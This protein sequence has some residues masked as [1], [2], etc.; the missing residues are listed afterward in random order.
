MAHS[1]VFFPDYRAAN[2]YQSLLYEHSAPE[3]HPR[4]ATIGEAL[5][6]RARQGFEDG[7]IFHLHWEDAVYRTEPDEGA[8]RAAAE[9]FVVDL[10]RFLDG[11]GMVL[12]T[13]HNAAP[14]DD[15]FPAVQAA[16]RTALV[17]LVDLVHVHGFEA[18]GWARATLGIGPER[19]VVVPH[20]NYAPRFHPKSGPKAQ[21]RKALGLAEG[22]RVL[23]L[24]GRLD[25]Y[26]GAAEL[27]EATARLDRPD[28]QVILAGRQVVPLD[29]LLAA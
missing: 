24:F 8:A 1:L 14:H 16:L 19:L 15:R 25:A 10:E 2:P 22:G 29:P 9:R 11:G 28:L 17:Q 23:L 13:V 12:W 18:A 6:L 5:E 21:G 7:A 20:G 4:P 27:L 3:L 26:K